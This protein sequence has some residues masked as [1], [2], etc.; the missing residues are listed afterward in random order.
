MIERLFNDI[1]YGILFFFLPF[2]LTH[3]VFRTLPLHGE[4]LDTTSSFICYTFIFSFSHALLYC[5]AIGI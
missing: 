3:K 5:S 2:F 4:S 1:M